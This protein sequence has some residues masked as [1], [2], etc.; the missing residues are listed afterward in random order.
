MKRFLS[1]IIALSLA[2]GVFAA[3]P[4]ET[5][6]VDYNALIFTLNEDGES[7]SVAAKY[8]TMISGDVVIPE[9]YEGLPVTE[10]TDYAFRADQGSGTLIKTLTIPKTI[11]KIGLGAFAYCISFSGVYITDLSA[12]CQIEFSKNYY[13]QLKSGYWVDCDISNPL[14]FTSKLYVNDKLVKNLVIPEGVTHISDE[15]F[16]Y[17]SGA[18]QVTF[19]KTLESIGEGAFAACENVKTVLFYGSEEDWNSLDKSTRNPYITDADIHFL[20]P[21]S[22]DYG[23]IFSLNPDKTGYTLYM[24][25][26][27]ANYGDYEIPSELNNLPVTE[28]FD[29]AFQYVD[30]TTLNIPYTVTTIGKQAFYN[31]SIKT[32]SLTSN[33]TSPSLA[34]FSSLDFHHPIDIVIFNG[35]ET[36]WNKFNSGTSWYNNITFNIEEEYDGFLTFAKNP[37]GSSYSVVDCNPEISGSFTIPETF[38]GY[39]VTKIS[40][41]AFYECTGLTEINF[42]NNLAYID[43]LAFAYCSGLTELSIPNNVTT[44]GDNAFQACSGLTSVILSENLSKISTRTFSGCNKLDEINI[45]QK[46]KSIETYAFAGCPLSF[47]NITDIGKWCEIDFA[48]SNTN[49]IKEKTNLYLNGELVEN[50][51]VPE[52]TKYISDYAFISYYALKTITVSPGVTSI[53]KDAFFWCNSLT[54]VTLSEG[55]KIIHE[56][57]FRSCIKLTSISLPFSLETVC[58]NAF[59]YCNSSPK[60]NYNGTINDRE[61][62]TFASGNN[63]FG[64][65]T[66]NPNIH[67]PGEWTIT[68]EPTCTEPGEKELRCEHCQRLMETAEVAPLDHNYIAISTLDTHPH[69]QTLDCSRCDSVI[70]ENAF[71]NDCIS[72]LCTFSRTTDGYEITAYNG[73]N[74]EFVIPDEYNG[75]PVVSIASEALKNK[76]TVTSVTMG[77]NISSIGADA[78]AGCTALTGVYVDNI[79]D[80]LEIDFANTLANPLCFAKKLYVNGTLASKLVVPEGVTEIKPYSF[81]NFVYM[82]SVTHPDSLEKIGASAFYYCT[83]LATVN[84]GK[85]VSVIADD[86]FK[87]CIK[88]KAVNYNGTEEDK[89]KITIGSNNEYLTNASWSCVTIQHNLGEWVIITNPTCTEGGLKEQSC[90]DCG[91]VINSQAIEALGHNY[92]ETVLDSHPHT[93]TKA[94]S[95]C[96]DN[97]STS[98]YFTDCLE[99]NFTVTAVDM[100][101]YKVV[102]YIGSS[103]NV[104]IPETYNNCSVTSIGNG[105]FK[106]NSTIKSIEIPNS[107]TSIGSL[108]FMNCTALKSITV[109]RSVESIGSQAFYGF[110]GVIYCYGNSFAHSYAKENNLTYEL[111][112]GKITGTENTSIDHD[113]LLIFTSINNC[114][115]LVNMFGIPSLVEALPIASFVSGNT[116]LY[117][118]GTTVS[119]FCEGEYTGDYTV[120]VEGDLNG[121]SVCDALD[122][123][124]A[125]RTSSGHSTPTTEEIYAANGHL[126]D[127]LDA[128][129]YQ[130]VVNTALKN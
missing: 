101:S 105:C 6:A 9:E 72:C 130:N 21:V 108:A 80:W 49:P 114:T 71:V 33:I 50:A 41:K 30:I 29:Y 39:P 20:Q 22:D 94:C 85:S 65:W 57:A 28:I 43:N 56:N 75:L 88:L 37:D 62:I 117:G 12:W 53:G 17:Y 100:S 70:T 78:F 83:N 63:Y 35:T 103:R 127:T 68:K 45:P 13:Q 36:Q 89:A 77:K 99:C 7:Y 96:G 121:D 8:P 55:V 115:D 31:S 19:P 67:T 48:D 69:T 125:E 51:V 126:S 16:Y 104:S 91:E 79:E 93:V 109:P 82:T 84:L 10:I 119:V 87:T 44:I 34:A 52:G 76:N 26:P 123:L 38:N 46:V 54:S 66:Y 59:A 98:Q 27:E 15:A 42:S 5:F 32:L 107:V 122:A 95:R 58:L 74:T 61:Y 40:H 111:I 24:H 112:D 14:F 25:N 4:V 118:T 90:L 110:S 129:S 113:N 60:V 23:T 11:K 116:E 64:S 102:S 47:V 1:L 120:I 86:A 3:A 2:I 97:Q 73:T 81:Y 128:S 106:N 92:S 18:E 124:E